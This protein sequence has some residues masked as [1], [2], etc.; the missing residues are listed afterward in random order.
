[1]LCRRSRSPAACRRRSAAGRA[2]GWR[3]GRTRARR[4]GPLVYVG[5]DLAS[6]SLL[7]RP[8]PVETVR[9]HVR[10]LAA[11]DDHRW[12]PCPFAGASTYSPTMYHRGT[13]VPASV[14]LSSANVSLAGVCPDPSGQSR[15]FRDFLSLGA[16]TCVGGVVAAPMYLAASR[17]RTAPDEPG[18]ADSRPRLGRRVLVLRTCGLLLA[19]PRCELVVATI[20]RS[21]SSS[22]SRA[23][24]SLP[25]PFRRQSRRF[26]RFLVAWLHC[27]YKPSD[28][29]SCV[30]GVVAAPRSFLARFWFRPRTAPDEPGPPRTPECLGSGRRVLVLRTC[31]LLLARPRCELVVAT[32]PRSPSSS[33]SRARRSRRRSAGTGPECRLR[34][35]WRVPGA[36]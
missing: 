18:P 31:G 33:A 11:E 15:R 13:C 16:S 14:N 10:A 23:R 17:P 8:H 32:I 21:P 9:E 34:P 26:R 1:M 7:V 36:G 22:A 28:G 12:E 6:T 2:P 25:G 24:R 30:G 27:G 29:R 19:R 20:P 4:P 3:R 5:L 35:R